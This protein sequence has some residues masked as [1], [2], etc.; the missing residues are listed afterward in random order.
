MDSEIRRLRGLRAKDEEFF[1]SD[2]QTLSRRVVLFW[3]GGGKSSFFSS[4][5]HCTPQCATIFIWFMHM[6]GRRKEALSIEYGRSI[7]AWGACCMN[8]KTKMENIAVLRPLACTGSEGRWGDALLLPPYSCSSP[9]HSLPMS[10]ITIHDIW[11]PGLHFGE[12]RKKEKNVGGTPIELRTFGNAIPFSCSIWGAHIPLHNRQWSIKNE[13]NV[14]HFLWQIDLRGP[15]L[16]SVYHLR[17]GSCQA[18]CQ[19]L[20]PA[21]HRRYLREHWSKWMIPPQ[22][23]RLSH[24]FTAWLE[25]QVEAGQFGSTGITNMESIKQKVV[26][27]SVGAQRKQKEDKRKKDKKRGSAPCLSLFFFSLYA[28]WH[29]SATLFMTWRLHCYYW[30]IFGY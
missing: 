14:L 13:T 15:H 11:K 6:R 24:Y 19:G 20:C 4:A 7:G 27:V 1:S 10:T 17:Q 3:G 29:H 21:F 28:V 25:K 12:S 9:C 23:W 30:K 16:Q 8:A 2:G 18:E 5:C 26:I 22:D